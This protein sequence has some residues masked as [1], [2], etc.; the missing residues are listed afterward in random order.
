MP[1]P[2]LVNLNPSVGGF[3]ATV[4]KRNPTI[5]DFKFRDGLPTAE[6]LPDSDDRPVDSELQELIPGLLKA[7]LLDLWRTRTDWL[8]G[9]DLGLYYDPDEPCIAPDGFLSVGVKDAVDENL[10]PSYVLW[11][12]QVIPLFVLEV[13]SKAYRQEHSKKLSIYQA[14]G[15]LY[16]VVYAPLRKRKA[17]FQVYKLINGAYVLQSEGGKPYWMP[18]IGLGI[19]SEP[20]SY[21][22]KQRE[23]LYWYDKK[24]QR[25]P[26]PT[27]RAESEAAARRVAEQKAKVAEQR[28]SSLMAQ[29]RE[30]GIDPET[31]ID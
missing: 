5:Q 27:E 23:L 24:G 26:T 30:L 25:Y 28:A 11:D 12:E 10:R 22:C 18:E 8:F 16:Y 1:T 20:G 13:V 15:I 4:H 31:I 17:R 7:I 9:I 21:G 2:P 6:E 19:G 29:L 14:I 3:S